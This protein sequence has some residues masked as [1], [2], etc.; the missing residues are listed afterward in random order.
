MKRVCLWLGCLL[1]FDFGQLAAQANR[2]SPPNI[3]LII[4]DDI[5]AEDLSCY[6]SLAPQ[7]PNLDQLAREGMLFNQ[8]FVTSSSCSPSRASILTG[9]YP[10]NTGAAELHSPV[11]SH[12]DYFPEMLKKGGYFTALAGKWHEGPAT[13]RAYDTLLLTDNGEGGEK[14]WENLLRL[15]PDGQPFFFWLA[16]HDAHR[17]FNPMLDTPFT[18]TSVNTVPLLVAGKNTIKDIVLYHNEIARLDRSVGRLLKVLQALGKAENTVVLFITD[19]GRPFPGSKTQ[20]YDRG[21]QSP[22]LIYWPAGIRKKGAVSAAL[23]SSLDLA[24][25]LLEIAGLP[26]SKKFQGK[27]F[28]KLLEMPEKSFR[29]YVFLEQNWHDYTAHARAIRTNRYLYI[30]NNHRAVNREGPLDVKASPAVTELRMG[31]QNQTLN[32]VQAALYE[33]VPAEEFYDNILDSSQMIN[34]IYDISYQKEI[35]KLKRILRRWTR[36]TGDDFPDNLTPDWYDPET[37]QKLPAYQTRG[38][39]PGEKKKAPF[40]NKPGPF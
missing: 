3:I 19:N 34:R 29:N 22:L 9:R 14:Q 12:L 11:P 40:I 23:I 17:S 16:A 18:T 20:L 6:N 38:Q 1:I 27:S 28:L 13:L 26:P 37:L 25:T 21:V 7:T 8:F 24:P 10:H 36:I 32:A 5:S 35:R 30:R 2:A 33:R 15:V 31:Y 4:G 39:M